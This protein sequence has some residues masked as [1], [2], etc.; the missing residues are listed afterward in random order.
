[1]IKNDYYYDLYE[2]DNGWGMGPGAKNQKDEE[3]EEEKQ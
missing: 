3:E 2:S 1:M